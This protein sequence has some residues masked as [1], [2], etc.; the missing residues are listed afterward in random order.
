MVSDAPGQQVTE[1]PACSS[2]EVR[3]AGE[4]AT[5][6][7]TDLGGRHFYQP[8]YTVYECA[9]C[10]LYFKSMT[11]TSAQLD[12]YYAALDGAT[13]DVDADFPTDRVLHSRL[14]ALTEGS[15]VL[16][17][18]CSTGR[19]LKD[20][21][22]HLECV[23]VEPNQ[24]AAAI[25][26]GRGIEIVTTDQLRNDQ[27][28]FDAILLTDV[29]EHLAQPMPLLTLLASRLS[30]DGW[31]AIVT[32]N[33][34]AIEPRRRLAEWWYF[35]LPGH[36]IMLGE[37]H[38]SWLASQLS[39][40]LAQVQR[41]SHYQVGFGERLRQRVQALA[42]DAFKDAPSGRIARAL[43]LLPGL[44]RARH[45]TSAPALNYRADHVV[46]FFTHRTGQDLRSRDA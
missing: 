1:C 18:G 16:D 26:R 27:R 23:G 42:Y 25:A 14:R 19:I 8:A 46:A 11:L 10:G 32:G 40:R 12:D 30:P 39:L 22:A 21:T 36:L 20:L 6:F 5:G 34:D 33:A 15:R 9:A 29:F 7:D 2:T 41:C 37:R 35:R 38:L 44:S 24:P 13:F 43:R 3:Q 17:F 45:W 28:T 31:L 4:P